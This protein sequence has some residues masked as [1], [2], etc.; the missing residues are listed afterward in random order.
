MTKSLE[1]YL[2]D[3]IHRYWPE[4]TITVKIEDERIV[5]SLGEQLGL[6]LIGSDDDYYKIVFSRGRILTIPLMPPPSG[7]EDLTKEQQDC[8]IELIK[9][10]IRDDPWSYAEEIALDLDAQGVKDYLELMEL[11]KDD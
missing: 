4:E 3:E 2:T 8:I 1:T 10:D 5:I 6:C 9:E 7:F 11:D